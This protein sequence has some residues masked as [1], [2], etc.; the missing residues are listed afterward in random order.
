MSAAEPEMSEPV[1]ELA[2]PVESTPEV[3]SANV[4]I[5][6]PAE[7]VSWRESLSPGLRNNPT[8]EQIPDLETL[9]KNHINVQKLIGAEKIQRPQE[10]WTP[11]QFDEFYTKMGRP[12]DAADYDLS[13]VE[14]P[15]GYPV[16]EG[17][18][19][20]MIEK[21]H[22]RGASQEMVAGILKDYYEIT[23]GQIEQSTG[24]LQRTRESGMQD[25]RNEWGKSYDGNVD[26]AVRAFHAGAGEGFE[27]VADL[28]LADGGKLGDHPAIIKAFATL[29]GKMNEHGLVGGVA[30]NYAMSPQQAGNER[31]KLMADQDFL[32]AYTDGTHLEHDAAVKRMNDLTIAEVGDE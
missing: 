10:D 16:D 24:D 9:A 7:P 20:T 13:N 11:E 14:V 3:E 30:S 17:F 19:S 8:L 12:T 27:Q 32:A 25:L 23:G 2:A 4:P 28:R 5:S 26:L 15:E 29:G 6:T 21:L 18:Q 31:N 22:A 1:S